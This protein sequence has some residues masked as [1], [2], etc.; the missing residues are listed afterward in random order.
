MSGGGEAG[1]SIP[2]SA[3]WTGSLRGSQIYVSGSVT[4]L[5]G[6][7][8]FVGAGPGATIGYSTSPIPSWLS[9]SRQNVVQAG[10]AYGLGGEI[11]API[12]HDGFAGGA[13]INGS[14]KGGCG[15]YGA[16]GPKFSTTLATPPLGC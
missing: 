16:G 6:V 8:G 2:V 12:T 5:S 15:L 11:S 7:G 1:V 9:F 4:P 13:S 10:A 14:L 3:L